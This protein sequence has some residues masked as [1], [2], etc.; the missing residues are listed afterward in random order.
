MAYLPA[1]FY[2][3]WIRNIEKIGKE[4]WIPILFCFLWGATIAIIGSLILEL[5][6]GVGVALSTS[7][8]TVFM[9]MMAVIIAPFAEELTK[10]IALRFKIVKKELVEPEDGLIY[11]AVAGLGFAATENLFYGW[12]AFVTEGF[13]YFIILISLRSITGC[14]IHASASAWTGYGYG[15]VIMKR[16]PFAKVI[17]YFL[18]AIAIHAFYNFIPV[19]GILTGFSISLVVAIIFAIISLYIVKNKIQT[20]DKRQQ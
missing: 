12:D 6:F 4:R 1:F 17:P 20:L 2:M 15:Q 10:P 11:G 13:L 9:I 8:Y 7:D 14:L 18:L 5:I 3:I 16:L 19:Y